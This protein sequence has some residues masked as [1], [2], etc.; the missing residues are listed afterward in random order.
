M[1]KLHLHILSAQATANYLATDQLLKYNII[2]IR[3]PKVSSKDT[4]YASIDKSFSENKCKSLFVSR[5]DDI[6]SNVP[7]YFLPQYEHIEN[8]LNYTKDIPDDI[9]VHCTAGISRSSAICYLIAYQK[10]L[11]ATRAIKYI[12]INL[13]MP[14]PLIVNY[15]AKYFNNF[16]IVKEYQKFRE[17]STDLFKDKLI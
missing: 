15:G 8:I 10:R 11:D 17:T 14:N 7:G 16:E 12:D 1:K 3:D 9:I 5:F 13:H 4:I 6:T 2:S